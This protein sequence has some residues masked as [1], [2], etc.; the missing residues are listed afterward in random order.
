MHL[1]GRAHAML[2]LPR[3]A[4]GDAVEIETYRKGFMLAYLI[5]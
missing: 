4:V 5:R 2:Q 1:L 3:L